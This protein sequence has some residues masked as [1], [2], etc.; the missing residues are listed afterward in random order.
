MFSSLL[1]T[2]FSL[3]DLWFML[4]GA[5]LT[6]AVTF[7]AVLIGTLLGVG[8][9]VTRATAPWWVNAPLGL[10]HFD[11]H[12]DT[13]P[14]SFGLV[15]GHGSPFYHAIEE[16]LIDGPRLLISLGMISQTGG[17]GDYWVPADMR[18]KKRAWLPDTVAD[19]VEEIRRLV[20]DK[21]FDIHQMRTLLGVDPIPLAKG[22]A[23]TFAPHQE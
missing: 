2:S 4:K 12:V 20:E 18:I 9:G 5:G 15:F 17:H 6:L 3:N 7:W 14:E 8:F 22:L 11:G 1:D 19:G 16:G 13:W 23:L 10:V 21:A